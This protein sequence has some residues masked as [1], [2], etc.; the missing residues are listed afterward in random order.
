MQRPLPY[1]VK[2]RS[3]RGLAS[4]EFVSRTQ[5]MVVDTREWFGAELMS[6]RSRY[7]AATRTRGSPRTR[8][9]VYAFRSPVGF[10][11]LR[12]LEA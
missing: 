5:R 7:L 9:T 3:S 1:H 10:A 2:A 11:G 12:V 6:I 4:Q 8:A